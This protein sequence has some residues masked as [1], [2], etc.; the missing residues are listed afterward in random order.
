MLEIVWKCHTFISACVGLS[1]SVIPS[2]KAKSKQ[3]I[4]GENSF[5][6]YVNESSM[7]RFYSFGEKE[8]QEK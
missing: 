8:F 4:Y 2:I 7:V 1:L 6:V 3:S 5:H